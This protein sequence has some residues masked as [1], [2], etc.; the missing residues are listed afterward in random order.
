MNSVL[1]FEVNKLPLKR[2]QRRGGSQGTFLNP[3]VTNYRGSLSKGKYPQS[4]PTPDLG[5][6]N[7]AGKKLEAMNGRK[8]Y[9]QLKLEESSIKAE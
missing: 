9:D 2:Q 8:L 3:V 6:A 1:S 5:P 7:S 4:Q